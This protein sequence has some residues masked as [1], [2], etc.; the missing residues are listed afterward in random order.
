MEV[1]C[2]SS[3]LSDYFNIINKINQHYRDN[4]P[5]DN[6]DY[7]FNKAEFLSASCIETKQ[8][9]YDIYS[10]ID[11]IDD[12]CIMDGMPHGRLVLHGTKVQFVCKN[13]NI[14]NLISEMSMPK[15][16]S[17]LT[18]IDRRGKIQE[19]VTVV[20]FMQRV[21]T[22]MNREHE[23]IQNRKGYLY[24]RCGKR[25]SDA[26]CDKTNKTNEIQHICIH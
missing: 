21:N 26:K 16:I 4:K 10:D 5:V 17:D 14:N 18:F 7:L 11:N 3:Y 2:L 13:N 20:A 12:D 8:A 25:Y 23:Y 19:E 1:F 6:L 22:L 9:L 24:E 15:S